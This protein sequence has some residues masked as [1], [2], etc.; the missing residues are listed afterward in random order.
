KKMIINTENDLIRRILNNFV[1]TTNM[2]VR[3]TQEFHKIDQ[4]EDFEIEIIH[5]DHIWRYDVIVKQLI[6]EATFGLILNTLHERTKK[7]IVIT[8]Y[9]NPNVA[10]K[11]KQAGVQYMDAA[12]NMYMKELPLYIEIAGKKLGDRIESRA[13]RRL[14]YP[15]GLQVIFGLLC[16]PELHNATYR[17]IAKMTGAALGTVGWTF[18][19]L[20]EAGYLVEIKK[21][22]R[23]V[24][25]EDLLKKWIENYHERLRPKQLRGKYIT[26]NFDWW[27]NINI[28]D[29]DADWG[30]EVAAGLMT[31]YL[32][33]GNKTIYAQGNGINKLILKERMVKDHKGDIELLNKFWN[34]RTQDK[35]KFIVPPILVYADLIGTGDERNIETA[36]L[37]YD[38][39]IV[40]HFRQT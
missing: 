21:R 22:R 7:L 23:L 31:N 20:R 34:F 16:I 30:G 36:R 17:E 3:I 27:R 38:K 18:K 10:K 40:Q 37:I 39:E 6:N 1:K 35:N 26:N 11:M 9:I 8:N 25:R 32:I 28:A 29:Y 13:E 14:F 19:D 5:E 4:H 15:A 2:E 24:Q 12:G 33:P